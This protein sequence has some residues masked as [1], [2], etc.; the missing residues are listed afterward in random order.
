[1]TMTKAWLIFSLSVVAVLFSQPADALVR[2]A[3]ANVDYGDLHSVKRWIDFK[4]RAWSDFK[5]NAAFGY[6]EDRPEYE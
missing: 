2:L 3:P 6:P 4:K 1:M 5:R